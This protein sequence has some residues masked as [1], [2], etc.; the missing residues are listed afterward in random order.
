MEEKKSVASFEEVID[1]EI[2]DMWDIFF[3]YMADK[4]EVLPRVEVKKK[5]NIHG[6]SRHMRFLTM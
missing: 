1:T 3:P 2:D 4:K 5:S 6:H